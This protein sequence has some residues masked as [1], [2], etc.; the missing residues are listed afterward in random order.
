[1]RIY[2][3]NL[4]NFVIKCVCANYKCETLSTFMFMAERTCRLVGS[5]TVLEL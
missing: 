1:M 3:P 4:N 2:R 5:I